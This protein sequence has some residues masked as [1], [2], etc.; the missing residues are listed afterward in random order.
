MVSSLNSRL[1]F[2][3][4]LR[5]TRSYNLLIIILTQYLVYLFLLQDHLS[6][7]EK[8]L[9]ANF[10]II[11]LSTICIAAAGYIINDYH[12]VKIDMIN[13]P[14]KVVIGEVFSRRMAL[15]LYSS[16]C[17]V[18]IILG[19][20]I[21]LQIGVINIFAAG[22]LWAYSVKFKK[23]AFWGN[24]IIAILTALTVLIIFVW[25]PVL[26][27]QALIAY[28]WFAF[29]ITL[30]REIIKDIEDLKGDKAFG[31]RTLPVIWGVARTVKII[32]FFIWLMIASLVGAFFTTQN[33]ILQF[34]AVVVMAEMVYL[35]FQLTRTDTNKGF[36]SLGKFCKIV[37]LTGI[38]AMFF[39]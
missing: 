31:C 21:S 32:Q 30:I 6:L 25:K 19:F 20:L 14:G 9:N 35:S 2:L 12:D 4:F 24:F 39:L 3:A 23:T 22:L 8:L 26:S 38:L 7:S 29:I 11:S 18:G 36:R 17:T 13:K 1:S 15:V 28:A 10:L 37:M 27:S 33:L 16:L 34:F 5:L